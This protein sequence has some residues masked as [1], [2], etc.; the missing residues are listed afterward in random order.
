MPV[1]LVAGIARPARLFAAARR[2]GFAVAGELA[3]ADH[4]AY[5]AA[6]L[7]KI[8]AA[9]AAGGARAVLTT[10]KDRVKLLG[11]LDLPLAEL[12]VAAAPEPAFWAWLADRLAGLGPPGAVEGPASAAPASHSAGP[13]GRAGAT[14]SAPE[15]GTPDPL[16]KPDAAD[17][18]AG[19]GGGAP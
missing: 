14:G 9:F 4:H 16:P 10:G 17:E 1:L 18:P 11:R 12:P 5:P 6:S 13:A 15:P 7:A 3:F 8:R 19:S 2:L